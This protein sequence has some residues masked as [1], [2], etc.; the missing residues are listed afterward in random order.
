AWLSDSLS[1][2]FQLLPARVEDAGRLLPRGRQEPRQHGRRRV[3][4]REQLRAQLGEPRERRQGLHRLR[5]ED[6]LPVH[7]GGRDAQLRVVL[8]ELGQHLREGHRIAPVRREPAGPHEHGP[9]R[10][11]GRSLGRLLR[12][13]VLHDGE[14]APRRAD[15]PSQLAR[16]V[17]GEPAEIGHEHVRRVPERLACALEGRGLFSAIQG[18][19]QTVAISTDAGST[20]TAG[21]I[22][23]ERT[24]DRTYLPLA[25]AGFARSTAWITAIAFSS[26][27]A[28]P[29]ETLPTA[30][31]MMAVLSTRNSTLPPL[32]SVTA[33]ATSNVTVPVFGFGMSPRGP[34]TFPSF[35]TSRIMSGVAMTASK[36]VHP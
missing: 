21:P 8:G 22:V 34:R 20:F 2:G 28:S 11:E 30:T 33:F 13:A 26:S 17:G 36:S 29:N 10:V 12:E 6:V 25:A 1:V 4:E 5:V 9:E 18:S 15:P 31:W 24:M 3:Q 19:P 14:G 7:E 27:F 16:L 23:D 32:I 35:P